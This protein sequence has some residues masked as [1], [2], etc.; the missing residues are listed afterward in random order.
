MSLLTQQIAPNT[1]FLDHVPVKLALKLRL[2]VFH[3][4]AKIPRW[5]LKDDSITESVASLRSSVFALDKLSKVFVAFCQLKQLL[6][7]KA[8][9]KK[10]FLGWQMQEGGWP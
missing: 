3:D 5:I 9:D 7:G 10:F 4:H 8:K 1:N 2:V 6:L